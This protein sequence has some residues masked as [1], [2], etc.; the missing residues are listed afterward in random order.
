MDTPAN[1]CL[2]L[3][4]GSLNTNGISSWDYLQQLMNTNDIMLLQET[5]LRNCQHHL[6]ADKLHDVDYV[7]VSAMDDAELLP[8]AGRPY[9]GLLRS[10]GSE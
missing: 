1:N 5:W 6:F 8:Q 7:A 9:G 2:G 3:R 4:I 10:K